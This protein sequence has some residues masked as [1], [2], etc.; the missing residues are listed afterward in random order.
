MGSSPYWVPYVIWGWNREYVDAAL[1]LLADSTPARVLM[2]Q[3]RQ[4]LSDRNG[5]DGQAYRGR[6]HVEDMSVAELRQEVSENRNTI[7]QLRKSAEPN[8]RQRQSNWQ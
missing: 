2:A 3:V 5:R 6:E 1:Q 7:Y 4:P 8:K